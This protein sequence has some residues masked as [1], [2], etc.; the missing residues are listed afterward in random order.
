MI[1]LLLLVGVC[2]A[3]VIPM[4]S[5]LK[6]QTK[7]NDFSIESANYMQSPLYS[8]QPRL[9][10]YNYLQVDPQKS[11]PVLNYPYG[12]P[13]DAYVA[14]SFNYY[15]SPLYNY[16]FQLSPQVFTNVQPFI[17]HYVPQ[18]PS[19]VPQQPNYVPQQ[20]NYVPQQPSYVPQEPSYVPQQPI[21]TTT[22]RPFDDD[23]IEKLDEKVDPNLEMNSFNSN[24]NS[25]DDSVVI[26]SI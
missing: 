22:Q 9:F 4:E 23:G 7:L 24:E 17:P 11:Y 1:A 25:D 26:E 5:M 6:I 15:G 10:L 20:P 12:N 14:S 18:Q 21:S 16:G 3:A 19:Y 8:H 2:G 13:G